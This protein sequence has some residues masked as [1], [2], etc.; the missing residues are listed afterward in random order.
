MYVIGFVPPIIG[1]EDSFNTFRLGSFYHKRLSPGDHVYLLNEKEKMVIGKA[2]VE[3]IEFGRLDELCVMYA[4]RNHTELQ[5]D[6]V[7]APARLYAT[8]QK[9]YGPH[10][11]SPSKKATV[12][13]LRR[14]QC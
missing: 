13:F 5:N 6:A 7:N 14:L 2:L 4:H 3:K 11:V 1:L 12:I 8:L 10:I 9:I